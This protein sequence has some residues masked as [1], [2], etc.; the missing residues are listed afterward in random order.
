MNINEQ[1]K[2][3]KIETLKR[4]KTQTLKVYELKINCHHTSKEIFAKLNDTF[5]QA[6]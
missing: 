3:T 6:K 5:K 2:Q 4:R 1:I